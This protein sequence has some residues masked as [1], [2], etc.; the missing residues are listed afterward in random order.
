MSPAVRRAETLAATGSVAHHKGL[1]TPD[2]VAVNG[3]SRRAGGPA[4]TRGLNIVVTLAGGRTI[5]AAGIRLPAQQIATPLASTRLTAQSLLG[6]LLVPHPMGR[7]VATTR[8]VPAAMPAV[9]LV[10]NGHTTHDAVSPEM[11][12]LGQGIATAVTG[13]G[14]AVG[15]AVFMTRHVNRKALAALQTIGAAYCFGV[16]AAVTSGLTASL[17]AVFRLPA[18]GRVGHIR[19]FTVGA[20]LVALTPADGDE[21]GLGQRAV[22]MDIHGLAQLPIAPHLLFLATMRAVAHPQPGG[23]VVDKRLAADLAT[24]EWNP[25]AE[26]EA[27]PLARAETAF[28]RRVIER[29]KATLQAGQLDLSA[30]GIGTPAFVIRVVEG[31]ALAV[32]RLATGR[33]TRKARPADP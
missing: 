10:F 8:T 30:A 16:A 33:A 28:A 31:V 22:V 13:T 18:R 19:H 7:A 5:Q 21:R 25:P 17:R 11:R 20:E 23:R 27:D 29:P 24:Q 9:L 2:A 12:F 4:Q 26:A 15:G 6:A 32:E 1:P 3:R 14:L